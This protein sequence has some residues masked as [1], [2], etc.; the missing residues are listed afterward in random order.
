MP[1]F[2]I[3]YWYIVLVL[4]TALL[5]VWAGV[6]VRSTFNKY[7]EVYSGLSGKEAATRVL[8]ANGVYDVEVLC[9]PGNLTDHFDPK[10]NVIRLSESVYNAR[11]VA[12]VGVAA[13]EAGH[14]VQ[15]AQSYAPIMIRNKIVPAVNF[16][17]NISWLVILIGDRKSVV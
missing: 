8:H 5:S 17:G 6:K 7:S 11:N 9:V 1:F 3:D 15:Y 2:F 13:H 12:A 16:G 14:A 4:P 10:A